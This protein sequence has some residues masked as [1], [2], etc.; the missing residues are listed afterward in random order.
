MIN[1]SKGFEEEGEMAFERFINW[2]MQF[3]DR[4]LDSHKNLSTH[5]LRL[6]LVVS[7]AKKYWR[8]DIFVSDLIGYGNEG[9]M[10]AAADYDPRRK[11]EEGKPFE[12]SIFATW[13]IKQRIS[14]A[15]DDYGSMIPLTNTYS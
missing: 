11:T 4:G 7:I 13:W 1:A 3:V 14:K 8:S 6:R 2:Q 15:I 9:L 10:I 12:F 5:N